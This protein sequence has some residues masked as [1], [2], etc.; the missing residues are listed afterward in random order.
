M[1]RWSSIFST[2]GGTVHLALGQQARPAD[3]D[4]L[5]VHQCLSRL[6][7][8]ALRSCM[9]CNSATF[10]RLAS[11]TIALASGCSELASTAAAEQASCHSAMPGAAATPRYRRGAACE[12]SGLIENHHVQI[13]GTFERESVLDEETI[14]GAK[15]CRNCNYQR[16]R[17]SQRVRAGNDEN[18]RRPDQRV[19]FVS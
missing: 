11:A 1:P 2:S 9:L 5:A 17:Q 18:R 16:N 12:C 7:R 4:A 10:R 14:L 8:P 19:F 6:D 13:A 3:D 15:R